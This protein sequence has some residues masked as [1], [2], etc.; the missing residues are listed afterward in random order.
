MSKRFMWIGAVILV[1]LASLIG[2]S[3]PNLYSG[4]SSYW[5][6]EC[7]V[8]EPANVKKYS[9]TYIGEDR[10]P[11]SDVQYTFKNSSNFQESGQHKGP[12]EKLKISGK[13]TLSAPYVNE[14][15]MAVQIRWNDKEE[16]VTLTKQPK[17]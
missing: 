12:T 6:I 3:R 7:S 13:A 2:C 4:K 9:I 8:N 16:T 17:E 11:V 14:G 1:V 15:S 10:L 5:N